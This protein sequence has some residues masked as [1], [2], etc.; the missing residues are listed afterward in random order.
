[1][2][3]V[4]VLVLS[5]LAAISCS[6][7]DGPT[8]PE[9]TQSA[10]AA[11]GPGTT[12]Y[13]CGSAFARARVD[14]DRLTLD[15]DGRR[16]LLSRA[17]SASGS[18]YLG[19]DPAI[20]FWEHRGGASLTVAG[21]AFSPCVPEPEANLTPFLTDREWVVEDIARGGIIDS[22]RITMTFAADGALSGLAG[23]NRYSGRYTLTGRTLA[24]GQLI[25]TRMACAPALMNQET[26]FLAILGEA[27]RAGP[28]DHGA[29]I[30][31]TGAGR[32]LLAR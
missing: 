3:L 10:D 7:R 15:V 30:I 31:E 2:K 32:R 16:Y 26:A 21:Q 12:D 29:L 27:A 20:E 24:T 28:G 23:C 25:S 6:N 19:E 14:A 1:M 5:A 17:R 18:R 22:S 11:Q 13:L 8:D 4:A 9:P